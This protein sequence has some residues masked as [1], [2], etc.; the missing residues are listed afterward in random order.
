V[1][2]AAQLTSPIPRTSD[3]LP[4]GLILAL[5]YQPQKRPVPVKFPSS[6]VGGLTPDADR[7][8][9]RKFDD[10]I[11]LPNGRTIVTLHNPASNITALPKEE[12]ALSEW[13]SAIEAPM[14]MVDL[15]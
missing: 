1:L 2:Q 6:A 7:G 15:G 12:S 11:L 3:K 8:W 9:Q 4:V 10:P 5:Y 14:L 13:W